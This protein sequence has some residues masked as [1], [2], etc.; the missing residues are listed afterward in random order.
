MT[1]NIRLLVSSVADRAELRGSESH[2]SV[3]NLQKTSKGLLWRTASL[4]ARISGTLAEYE[5]INSVVLANT[6]MSDRA[7][8]RVQLFQGETPVYD[9][10][11][12]PYGVLVPAGVWAA[13]IDPWGAF[14]GSRMPPP[15]A[16]IWLPA[17]YYADKFT[18]TIDDPGTLDGVIDVGRLFVGQYISP[19][20]N[21]SYGAKLSFRDTSKHRLTQAGVSTKRGT[22]QRVFTCNLEV[23]T[24]S[25]RRE[26]ELELAMAGKWADIFLC[27]YPEEGGFTEVVHTFL[28]RRE[29]DF[30]ATHIGLDTWRSDLTLIEV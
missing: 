16:K 9:S 30:A 6:T 11:A 10:G 12:V 28:A 29:N 18:I 2:S 23:L 3:S 26:L 24:H 20:I 22:I 1:K 14:Y 17:T 8:V 27:A 5:A 21:F 13:G 4:P 15:I 7:S 25:D 19:E